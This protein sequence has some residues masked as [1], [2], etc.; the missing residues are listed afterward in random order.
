[1]REGKSRGVEIGV[2][3]MTNDFSCCASLSITN[4]WFVFRVFNFSGFWV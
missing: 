3:A 1:V 2:I 4:E